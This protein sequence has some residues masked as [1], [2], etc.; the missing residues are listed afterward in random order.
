MW[1]TT[2]QDWQ[3]MLRTLVIAALPAIAQRHKSGVSVRRLAI[4]YGCDPHWLHNQ[5]IKA[6]N[7]IRPLEER[8]AFATHPCR[9]HLS[10]CRDGRRCP[11]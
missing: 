5:L 9:G 11:D 2:E 7:R 1:A 8:S 4:V 6:G 10:A 3:A